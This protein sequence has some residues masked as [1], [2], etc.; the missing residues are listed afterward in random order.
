M[1]LKLPELAR[2]LLGT[3][4]MNEVPAI[5]PELYEIVFSPDGTVMVGNVIVVFVP[6]AKEV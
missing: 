6:A 5:V 2:L 3:L 1:V 4:S